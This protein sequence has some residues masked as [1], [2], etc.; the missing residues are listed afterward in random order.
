MK[1]VFWENIIFRAN[2]KFIEGKTEYFMDW[3]IDFFD[4][5]FTPD[6]IA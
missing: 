1:I 4:W 2:C 3:N 5:N 6:N